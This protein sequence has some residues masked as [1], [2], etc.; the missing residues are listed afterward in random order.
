MFKHIRICARKVVP[1]KKCNCHVYKELHLMLKH[2]ERVAAE[3]LR[4][5][6]HL[7]RKVSHIERKHKHLDV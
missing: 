5:M 6:D 1:M 4:L 7:Y 3:L 2:H